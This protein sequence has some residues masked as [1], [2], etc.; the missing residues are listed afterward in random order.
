MPSLPSLATK[1]VSISKHFH[2]LPFVQL[3]K[4]PFQRCLFGGAERET[5]TLWSQNGCFNIC[6]YLFWSWLWFCLYFICLL[7]LTGTQFVGSFLSEAFQAPDS[8]T[9]SRKAISPREKGGYPGNLQTDLL[10]YIHFLRYHDLDDSAVCST[11]ALP[12]TERVLVSCYSAKE[13]A[14]RKSAK[15]LTPWK[16]LGVKK[17]SGPGFAT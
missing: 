10:W 2:C 16:S 9:P 1:I 14:G 5:Q 13:G 12:Q 3:T 15:V 8:R 4:L 6:L 7:R 11:P 17:S